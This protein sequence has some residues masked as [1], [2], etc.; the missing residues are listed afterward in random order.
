MRDSL[1]RAARYFDRALRPTAAA[2]RVLSSETAAGNALVRELI[3]EVRAQQAARDAAPVVPAADV[4]GVAAPTP[5]QNWEYDAWTVEIIYRVLTEQPGTGIDV[6]AHQGDI[7]RSIIAASPDARH[8]A[9]EP[10][11]HLAEHLRTEFPDVTLHQV[12][13]AAEEGTSQFHHV[14]SNP[15]FSGIRQRMYARPDEEISLIDVDIR[16]LDD[17]VDPE[18]PV[19]LIKIDVEG[20]EL[21]VLQGA[22][23]TLG[24]WQPVVVFEFGLGASNFYGTTPKLIHDEFARHGMVLNL[25]D[26]WL[27]DAP[28]LS[29]DEFDAEY[30]TGRSYYFMAY[31]P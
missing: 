22:T 21:G 27:A 16:R 24:R 13:L 14:V 30:S 18:D 7:L 1:S 8:Y 2:V 19:R 9:F 29:F 11:P 25:L 31:R 20:A 15:G 6:G 12:A 28:A 17:L 23:R 5:P 4:P 3:A 26:R 10:L